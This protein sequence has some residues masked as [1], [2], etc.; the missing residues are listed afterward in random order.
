MGNMQLNLDKKFDN[1]ACKDVND[2]KEIV[3]AIHKTEDKVGSGFFLYF[4]ILMFFKL[5][6][7]KGT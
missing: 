3:K 4:V 7:I 1:V 6:S 2:A 5:F